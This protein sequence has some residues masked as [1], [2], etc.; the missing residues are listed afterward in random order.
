MMHPIIGVTSEPKPTK[1]SAGDLNSH[2]V[3][4]TYTDAVIRAGGLPVIL[5]PVPNEDVPAIIDRLDGLLLYGGG[6]VEPKRY[7][8]ES[9]PTV[10]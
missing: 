2:V 10:N 8:E 4:H 9:H 1:G 3:G 7:G 5:T 6:D